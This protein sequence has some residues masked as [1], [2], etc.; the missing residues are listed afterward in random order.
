MAKVTIGGKTYELAMSLY[1]MSQIED[2]FGD[3]R[4]AM[5]KFRGNNRSV[6]MIKAMFRIMA[7]A[8]RHAR[9]EPEDITGDEIDNVGLKG[10]EALSK[11]LRE[12]MDESMKAETVNGGLADDEAADVYAE[13][14]ERQEKNGLTGGGSA[15]GNTSDT[16]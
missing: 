10:L 11:A 16:P 5:Q 9:K 12:V 15:S 3:L 6:K 1:A 13:E 2:E 8:A 7:N 4:D 14:M